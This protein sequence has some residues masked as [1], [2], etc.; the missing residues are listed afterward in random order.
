MNT[1][2]TTLSQ[3]HSHYVLL[4]GA[5]GLV[6]TY[7]IRDLL[8][9]GRKL[10]VVARRSKR[11]TAVERIE[12]IMQRWE[13]IGGHPLPRPVVL[14]GDIAES[15]LGLNRSEI[16]WVQANVDEIIHNAAILKFSGSDMEQEPWRTNLGGTKNA[17]DFAVRAGIRN[18]NYVSTAYVCG[19]RSDT[20]YEDE[21][22]CGQ[23]FRNDY[24]HSKF[25]SELLVHAAEGFEQKTIFRPAVIVGDS[26]T[27]FTTTYHGLFLYLRLLAMLV[28]EQDRDENG[29]LI[30]PIQLPMSGDEPRNLVPVDWVSQVIAHVVC[31]PAA[32]GRTYHLSPDKCST[33]R[34]VIEACYRYFNSDGVEFVGASNSERQSDTEFAERFFENARIYE[35]Y[36]TSD[37][38]FDNRN[39]KRFAAHLKCPN[40]DQE[41]IMRFMEFGKKDN[42][43]KRPERLPNVAQW[44]HSQ[45]D[46]LVRGAEQ[47]DI[48]RFATKGASALRVGIDIHGPGGGQWKLTAN[49]D[50]CEITNGL[51]TEPH[52]VLKLSSSDLQE[53]SGPD[54]DAASTWA[55]RLSKI[56]VSDHH[57]RSPNS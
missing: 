27:G 52:R 41:M 12:S 34:D 42:W 8:L 21:L 48:N 16:E 33:A 38:R 6:G 17:I 13:A 20:I 28:P 15:N 4:T 51:P 49:Q 5:T 43:G 39:L 25:R 50:A 7:L 22:E 14:E 10:V 40:V 3:L 26:K 36:E 31:T 30:T 29:K 19:K 54:D 18:F 55:Q 2:P 57:D 45:L 24:E 1:T 56:F 46:D 44:F 9:N 37:P 47:L 35:A 23:S 53:A 32:K 11:L